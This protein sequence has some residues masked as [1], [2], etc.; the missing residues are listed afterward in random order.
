MRVESEMKYGTG[1]DFDRFSSREEFLHCERCGRRLSD[2]DTVWLELDQRTNTYTNKLV[3]QEH[4]QG[5]FAF[6]KDCAK[7]EKSLHARSK[8]WT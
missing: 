4:S 6:G 3:P 8:V 2:D 5:S 1:V 7:I